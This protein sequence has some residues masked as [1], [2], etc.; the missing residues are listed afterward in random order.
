MK[1]LTCSQVPGLGAAGVMYAPMIAGGYNVSASTS[2]IYGF[3][4]AVSSL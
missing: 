4:I 1:R 2:L 3:E